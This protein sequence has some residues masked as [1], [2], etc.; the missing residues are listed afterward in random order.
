MCYRIDTNSEWTVPTVFGGTLNTTD[1]EGMPSLSPDNQKLYF[2]SDRPGGYGGKDIWV[3]TFENNSWSSPVNAGPAIN[4]RGDELA[5][6]IAMDNK[7]LFFTSDGLPGMGGLD[8]YKARRVND[9]TWKN[10]ENLGYPINTAYDEMSTCLSAGGRTL[11]FSSDRNGP[12]GNYDIFSTQLPVLSAPDAVSYLGGIVYDS[13]TQE[14][15]NSAAMFLINAHSGDTLYRFYSNRGD[16]SYLLPVPQNLTYALH[17]VRIGYTDIHDTFSFNQQYTRPHFV[18]NVAMLPYDYVKP[19]HDSLI[20][21]VHFNI[22]KIEL[23]DSDKAAIYKGIEP[24]IMDKGI[25]LYVNGFTDNTGNPL[26]NAELSTKRAMLVEKTLVSMGIDELSI[27]SKGWGEA[28]MVASNETE[29][30]QRRNRR[31]EII[32]RRE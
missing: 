26:L 9:S 10:V 25:V 18:R 1:Y 27:I 23:S 13:I 11:Y 32:L 16:A 31:V 15:L 2:V 4:T 29:E 22:N 7:T 17:T 20:A 14:R 28:K 5:P 19:I 30:G 6:Y 12:A 8:L 24:F 3:T 21:T